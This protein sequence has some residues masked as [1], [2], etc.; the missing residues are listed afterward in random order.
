MFHV[1][2]WS[3][4]LE[5][6][7]RTVARVPF[8]TGSFKDP[9]SSQAGQGSI[10]VRKDW[11][12]LTTVVDPD[13]NVQS[14]LVVFQDNTYVGSFL[15]TRTAENVEENGL[16]TITGKHVASVL[17]NGRVL[18]YDY[19][20]RPTVDPDWQWGAGV[21]LNGFRNG[22]FEESEDQPGEA[23][24]DVSTDFEDGTRQ[25]WLATRGFLPGF[26]ENDATVKVNTD[27]AQAGSYSM[28]VNA[29]IAYSG[30]RKQVRVLGGSTVNFQW[31]MKSATTGKHLIGLVDL[32][33]GTASHTNAYTINNRTYAE[34]GNAAKGTGTT[35]GTWQLIQLAVTYPTFNSSDPDLDYKDVWI[36]AIYDDTGNGPL[37]RLDTFTASGPGFGLLP[38]KRTSSTDVTVFEQDA[39]HTDPDDSTSTVSAKITTTAASEGIKQRCDGLTPGRTY[40]FRGKIYHETGSA[41]DFRVV[42]RRGSGE[43]LIAGN[44]DSIPT[45][46]TD[47]DFTWIWV[48][49][50]VDQEDI[51]F[52]VTKETAGTFWLDSFDVIEGL[53][54]ASWGDIQHQ[55]LDDLT[56]DHVAESTSP[57][58]LAVNAY[59]T[60][61]PTTYLDYS[62][63]SATLDSASNAWSPATVEY[64]AKRGKK[65]SL[66]ASDGNRAGF[67][68]RVAFDPAVPSV[69]LDWFNP[70]DWGTRTGG[71]GTN[72][73]GTG[74]KE[75]RAATGV[76][77][78]PV[79]KQAAAANRIYVEGDEGKWNVRAKSAS[80]TNYGTHMLYEGDVNVLG[81]D[82]LGQIA[83][84]ILDERNEPSTALKLNIEPGG[85]LSSVVPYRDFQIGDTVPIA[86][87]G[88]FEGAK[89]VVQ[90]VTDFTPGYGQY[91]V[92]FDNTTFTSDPTKALAEAVRRLLE[93]VDEL[94]KPA[95]ASFVSVGEQDSTG[96]VGPIDPTYFIASADCRD[97]LK[98]VADYVCTGSD[99]DVTINQAIN[100]LAFTPYGLG[101]FVLSS[102][103]FYCTAPIDFSGIP[104][105]TVHGMGR[106]ATYM[107]F[108]FSS[109]Q[110]YM[111]KMGDNSKIDQ[112]AL[113]EQGL[114]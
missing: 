71:V 29:G 106:E 3:L 34:L 48:T 107:Y 8:I 105:C 95:D 18:N 108:S 101:R 11:D 46:T 13:N 39:T 37:M 25:G 61:T 87:P 112:L 5:T 111:V 68:Y 98:A 97:A 32:A 104:S 89:R 57:I 12:R 10:V 53:Y 22:G 102:G 79:I 50:E 103:N 27:D 92:E 55:L 54:A 20:A 78:G 114:E 33:G 30:F 82:T 35:D 99:D 47:A 59:G 63:F 26:N 81:D 85:N 110:A 65:L 86:I 83:R 52:V 77:T 41:Q 58:P 43:G 16:V 94:E 7:T 4:P 42:I 14:L 109:P 45:G 100:D 51:V 38:W 70:Y 74:V 1:E 69:V 36:Y 49:A 113:A 96:A 80:E 24:A 75:I 76:T 88:V 21:S 9:L 17:E 67:E 40:T 2:A 90:I 19:P 73:V 64:R 66:I 72:R 60:L 15:G 28:E 31:Y 91:T 56:V 84:R 23:V 6:T 44:T 93:R 62:S